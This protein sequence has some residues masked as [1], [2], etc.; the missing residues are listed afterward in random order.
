MQ[1]T[2]DEQLCNDGVDNNENCLIDLQDPDCF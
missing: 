1:I 2:K